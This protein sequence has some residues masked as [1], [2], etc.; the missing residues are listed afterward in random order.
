MK[1]EYTN[2]EVT[3]VWMPDKCTH[4]AFCRTGLGEVFNPQAR[5]WVNMQG[6]DTEKIIEQV[7]KCPSKAL[8]YYINTKNPTS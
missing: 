4:S 1:K 6:A 8:S 2:G 7:K 3:V 5:P